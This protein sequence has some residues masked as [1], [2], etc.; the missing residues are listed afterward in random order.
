MTLAKRLLLC[1]PGFLAAFSAS[2][3]D[4]VDQRDE[5]DDDHRSNGDDSDGGHA[6]ML[7]LWPIREN[8]RCERYSAC[9]GE[10]QGEPGEHREVRVKHDPLDAANAKRR[11]AVLPLEASAHSSTAAR[12]RRGLS[13]D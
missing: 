6:P 13:T 11:E 5:G 2:T 9:P 3:R 10:C 7:P 4:D 8:R 12:P 1:S